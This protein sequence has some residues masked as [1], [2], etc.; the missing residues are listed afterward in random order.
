MT[1][2][3]EESY[4]IWGNGAKVAQNPALADN[5][6]RVSEFCVAATSNNQYTLKMIDSYGDSWTAGSWISIEGIYGNIVYK[7]FLTH[8]S[9]EVLPISLYYG[10]MK[11]AEWRLTSSSVSGNWLEYNYG[12]S[13]WDQVTLGSV[14]AFV[15]ST[16]YFRKTFTGLANM[17][18]YELS[19]NYRYGI[20]AYMNGNEVVRDNMP[21][22]VITSS[23]LATNSYPNVDYHSFIRPGTEVANTQSILAVEIHFLT[24]AGQQ[25]VDFDAFLAIYASSAKSGE[26]NCYVY[27]YDVTVTASIGSSVNNIF[28][29]NKGDYF[30][31]SS[32]QLP[33]T[34]TFNITGPKAF[35][36]GIRVWPYSAPQNAPT[37]YSLQG[38]YLSS[39]SSWA[40]IYSISNL[41]YTSMTF[42]STQ[43]HFNGNLYDRYRV[44]ISSVS[45]QS[46]SLSLYEMQL[47]IFAS[48]IPSS[49][50]YSEQ[51]YSF[52]STYQMVNIAPIVSAFTSCSINPLPP[53]GLTF[54]QTT[55]TLSGYATTAQSFITYTVTSPMIGQQYTGSFQ[56]EILECSG[57]LVNLLR[58]YK[59]N[60]AGEA[61]TIKD[62]TTQQAIYT[63]A[64]NSGQVNNHDWNQMLCLNNSNYEIELSSSGNYWQSNSFLYVNAFLSS[65]EYD[66]LIRAKFDNNLGLESAPEFN[67]Q[68][69]IKPAESWHYK[70]GEVPSNWFN[71]DTSGWTSG[72][73]GSFP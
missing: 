26:K 22:G 64:L 69:V 13:S 46:S 49:I 62:L 65:D 73:A 10:I 50:E 24:F 19:M 36:N 48:D 71:S 16:Q 53:A 39:S 20:V 47:V 58:T 33:T 29:W 2:A 61:F 57:T 41:A 4:E 15:F 35:I 60:A 25:S 18:A 11:N 7:G 68:F 67:A 70:M 27:P 44:Q 45:L 38:S 51:Q 6:L 43:G 42:L 14:T 63:V 30:S 31:A 37:S 56:L 9:F 1:W 21:D 12:D 17:A 3:S 54:N 72:T 32:S 40:T 52:Y 34:V 59:T 28:N 23:T 5:E 55:C 66:T 8:S